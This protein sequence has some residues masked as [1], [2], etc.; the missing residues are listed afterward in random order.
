VRKYKDFILLNCN[1]NPRVTLWSEND[2]SSYAGIDKPP[3]SPS[4]CPAYV[5]SASEDCSRRWAHC[6]RGA[7]VSSLRRGRT[8]R[9]TADAA[10][11][12]VETDVAAPAGEWMCPVECSADGCSAN[13]TAGAMAIA[14]THPVRCARCDFCTNR[15][16]VDEAHPRTR[17]PAARGFGCRSAATCAA[18]YTRE[19]SPG[20]PPWCD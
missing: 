2:P 9:R 18:C 13:T 1:E 15:A 8:L 4:A 14:R 17:L 12:R 5:P 16:L 20:A 3:L 7:V 10:C 19:T 6:C 11:C